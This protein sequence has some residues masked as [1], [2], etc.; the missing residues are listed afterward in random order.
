LLTCKAK[1]F[2]KNPNYLTSIRKCS[3]DNGKMGFD[4]RAKFQTGK[5][6]H[7]SVTCRETAVCKSPLVS[8]TRKEALLRDL[9]QM[10]KNKE[11]KTGKGSCSPFSS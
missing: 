4:C 1:G 9:G 6:H 2:L 3:N 10:Y 5:V 11:E 7:L 8:M